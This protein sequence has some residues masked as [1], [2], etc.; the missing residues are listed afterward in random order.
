MK[1][2]QLCQTFEDLQ[3]P[4]LGSQA[5]PE[6]EAVLRA[7]SAVGTAVVDDEFLADCLSLELRLLE[8]NRGWRGLVPFFTLP[9]SGVRLAFGYWP[10]GGTPGAHEHTAWT[11]T[12]VCRN[13]LEV[14]TFD[15][16]KSYQQR[17]LVPKNN[18]S[19]LAGQVGFIYE[20]CIHQPRN[21]SRDWSLSLHISSPRD[22]EQ[23]CDYEE[24][25][26]ALVK[27][28]SSPMGYD[29]PY[30][31]VTRARQRQRALHQ[32]ARI[33]AAMDVSQAPELLAHC[34]RLASSATRNWIDQTAPG[35][36]KEKTTDA[37]W[38]LA[39]T[40]IGLVLRPRR[41][42]DMWALE[43]ETPGGPIDEMII[44]DEAHDAIDFV[45]REP[46]FDVRALPGHLSEEEQSAIAQALEESG[47]FMRVRHD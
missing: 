12:A 25:L 20:P 23:L 32:L 15:R 28:G 9:G 16:A 13:Q 38:V 37:P 36:V 6:R 7:R 26:P 1:L 42:G 4:A 43:V 19:A 39:R 31:S 10:P 46:V 3:F 45:S 11:I 8:D 27:P 35:F 21:T 41:Q 14:L 24:P 30:T 17:E 47:L 33:L 2:D 22:G 5:H 34:Y 40:H 18:F 29:H 44:S